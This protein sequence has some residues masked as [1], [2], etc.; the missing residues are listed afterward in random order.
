MDEKEKLLPKM[1]EAWQEKLLQEMKKAWQDQ[2]WE[3]AENYSRQLIKMNPKSSK[4]Y[5]NRALI[6]MKRD[7][8]QGVQKDLER[9]LALDP[10][11][12]GAQDLLKETKRHLRSKEKV[13]H[14]STQT[15]SSN[16]SSSTDATHWQPGQIIDDRY[17][18]IKVLGKGAMGEVYLVHHLL[19]D[20]KLAVKMPLPKI[21]SSPKATERFTRE[22]QIWVDIDKHPNVVTAYYVRKLDGL[23]RIFTEYV[24][25]CDL[26]TYIEKSAIGTFTEGLDIA[27]QVVRGMAHTHESNL[28]HRDLKSANVMI[29]QSGEVKVTDLGLAKATALAEISIEESEVEACAQLTIAGKAMGTI[30]YMPPE[31]WRGSEIDFHADIY[32]FGCILYE[33]FCHRLP[34]IKDNEDTR[35]DFV[36]YKHM[37]NFVKAPAPESI[38]DPKLSWQTIP[39]ALAQLMMNCLE[40]EPANRPQSF[41][42][43]EKILLQIYYQITAKSY[44]D[45]T[46]AKLKQHAADLNNKALSYFD[47]GRKEEAMELL[48][49]A[50]TTNSLCVSAVLNYRCMQYRK[51]GLSSEGFTEILEWA[52]HCSPEHTGPDVLES[53][54]FRKPLRSFSQEASR[55]AAITPDGRFL[56]LTDEEYT[57]KVYDIGSG[58][59][60]HSL[61]GHSA[62]ITYINVAPGGR[63]AIS[64]SE[65]KTLQMWDLDSGKSI[66]TLCGYEDEIVHAVIT[67]DG[68]VAISVSKKD[69]LRIWDVKTGQLMHKLCGDDQMYT[70]FEF[71]RLESDERLAISC[72]RES[73]R[74]LIKVWDIHSGQLMFSS[75]G[76]LIKITPDGR[77]A[78]YPGQNHALLV[79]DLN[80]KQLVHTLSGHTEQ[81][82]SIETSP[83]G[84]F[85]ISGSK[86]KT[87]KVWNVENGQCVHTLSGHKSDV[88]SI[89]IVPNGS[90]AIS[91]SS[92]WLA[93]P[94]YKIVR[95]AF[96]DTTLRIWDIKSGQLVHELSGH[97]GHITSI[98]FTRDG[99]LM[100]SGSRDKTLRIWDL[101][102]GQCMCTLCGHEYGT[103]VV[104]AENGNFAISEEYYNTNETDE[105]VSSISQG[106]WFVWNLEIETT[107]IEKCLLYEQIISSMETMKIEKRA[108]D[109][110]AKIQQQWQSKN[111]LVAWKN[112]QELKKTSGY[113]QDKEV[114]NATYAVSEVLQYQ[115]NTIYRGW[116]YGFLAKNVHCET[117]AGHLVF[118]SNSDHDF[119]I[120][121]IRSK[122]LIHRFSGHTT[123][124]T[125]IAATRDENFA[126][127]A[128]KDKTVHIW[129]VNKK[130]RVHT[131][132]GSGPVAIAGG[133][134]AIFCQKNNLQ[135]WDIKNK[136]PLGRFSDH[137]GEITSLAVT[138]DERLVLSTSY[139]RDRND[140]SLSIWN[141]ISGESVSTLSIHKE[142]IRIDSI[143]GNFV[144]S[145]KD[146]L[147][148]V[149]D[150]PSEQLMLTFYMDYLAITP[151][152]RFAIGARYSTL[153]IWE[154]KSKKLLHELSGHLAKITSIAITPDARFVI[155]G[156]DKTIQIWDIASGK[157]LSKLYG[158][159]KPITSIKITSDSRFAISRD[160]KAWQFDWHWEK[161]KV[162]IDDYQI[163][164][165]LT[166][167]A[168]GE[169]YLAHDKNRNTQVVLKVLDK[170]I[171]KNLEMLERDVKIYKTM[172]YPPNT[173]GFLGWGNFDDAKVFIA[174]KYTEG[175]N[176]QKWIADNMSI[177]NS[178][179]IVFA[180]IRAL[181]YMHTHKILHLSLQPSKILIDKQSGEV[182]LLGFST[183]KYTTNPASLIRNFMAPELIQ[184]SE[185]ISLQ[186]DIY[187]LGAIL[188][189]LLSG[190][191]PYGEIKETSKMLDVKLKQTLSL[192]NEANIFTE[193]VQKAMVPEPQKRY[194]N[195]SHM[196]HALQRAVNS[197]VTNG[198]IDFDEFA[199]NKF[200]KKADITKNKVILLQHLHYNAQVVFKVLPK[201]N[202][203]K[204]VAKN[205]QAQELFERKIQHMRK[206]LVHPNIIRIFGWHRRAELA[207]LVMEY[208][209]AWSL[210][211]LITKLGVIPLKYCIQ[212]SICIANTLNYM[213]SHKIYYSDDL[214]PSNIL[215]GKQTG[216]VK[217]RVRMEQENFSAVNLNKQTIDFVFTLYWAPEFIEQNE[218][219]KQADIYSLG[220]ILYH[221][222]ANQAPYYEPNI[223]PIDLAMKKINQDPVPVQQ[224]RKNV[225]DALAK[226]IHKA[227]SRDP[228]KRYQSSYELAKELQKVLDVIT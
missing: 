80:R 123:D 42:E 78:I 9:V 47:L 149:W 111:Y 22:A 109:L 194:K 124:I 50:V 139:S 24:D 21:L 46:V 77:L 55:P 187:S 220:A 210:E 14:T 181:K 216:I 209:N 207:C 64:S 180:L 119:L 40:K 125:H 19:W 147:F 132:S 129:D 134:F 58:E 193:I 114:L 218:K 70:T 208:F 61:R 177:A 213:H 108:R 67:S 126:I 118:G 161:D 130:Q 107:K 212:I 150:I 45:K 175:P 214:T 168:T 117:I 202:D 53:L 221:T 56:I 176:L 135:V 76:N 75:S 57:L 189:Y 173:V 39:N 85:V 199:V 1:N 94:N 222:V 169:I 52:R 184:N 185:N 68:C 203:A 226:I 170:N 6:Q 116:F 37:H 16:T 4:N 196:A 73:D 113:E 171:F 128:S 17:E 166:N 28:V 51:E 105:T 69:V 224:L 144:I 160:G 101:E 2:D 115:R 29:S 122:Q 140:N 31:Q 205:P 90:L 145:K 110:K 81:I 95:P 191:I 137:T 165:K 100:V 38:K 219:S 8:W 5:Y 96:Y 192:D 79:W 225:P 18:T 186:A 174:M 195:V 200:A 98:A 44:P 167:G 60:L 32:A 151:G 156:S 163:K 88:T 106:N 74:P 62:K 127:S 102:S 120:W 26:K 43:I 49:E 228:K 82:L 91:C 215:I 87:L 204:N 86:D 190:Q 206:T 142:C 153:F 131:F 11:H 7:K 158:D 103:E 155:S 59:S 178:M 157:Q 84:L 146:G 83:D 99:R 152:G 15:H 159:T 197:Y 121:D 20:I 136:Q 89:N 65:D 172:A 154:T 104:I 143:V 211:Q 182:T 179:K 63:F 93:P 183:R 148:Q 34:F 23:L 30:A 198:N 97:T 71:I 72:F 3:K 201:T 13:T 33:I 138:P 35:S 36:A 41:R 54:F 12:T 112:V 162:D 66:C 133:R 27:I 164:E 227:L 92:A 188:Y 223:H 25:G 217:V 48:E 10:E 141:I